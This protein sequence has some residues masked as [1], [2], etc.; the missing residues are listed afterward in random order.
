MNFMNRVSN[1]IYVVREWGGFR[2][3]IWASI[4]LRRECLKSKS[5]ISNLTN[6]KIYSTTESVVFYFLL[7][8]S[9]VIRDTLQAHVKEKDR[10]CCF[11]VAFGLHNVDFLPGSN[12]RT[13]LPAPKLRIIV[14][15][16]IKHTRY[17]KKN[18]SAVCWCCRHRFWSALYLPPAP[19]HQTSA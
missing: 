13:S 3:A 1:D 17:Y 6:K 12:T 14:N 10:H 2:K 9:I 7:S 5:E 18:R 11:S 16:D 15:Y 19:R 8:S 4:L